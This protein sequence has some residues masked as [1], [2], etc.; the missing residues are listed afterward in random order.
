MDLLEQLINHLDDLDNPAIRDFIAQHEYSDPA[1]IALKPH[2]GIPGS[3]LA[4]QIKARLKAK[5]KLPTYYQEPGVIYPPMA[6]LAQTS[7]ELTAIHKLNFL[8]SATRASQLIDLT[9]G[10]GID[11]HFLAK[12]FDVTHIEPNKNLQAL[13][14]FNH[15]LLG[16][17]LRYQNTDAAD[18]L[19][20]HF[21]E[22]IYY[23]DPSRLDSN[24]NRV[25]KLEEC[26]PDVRLIHE[27]TRQKVPLLLKLSPL[28]DIT[29]L[30]KTL[31]D[32]S[33]VRVVAVQN[34]VKEVLALYKPGQLNTL[35]SAVNIGKESTS[36]FSFTPDEEI[37]SQSDISEPLEYIYEPFLS[38][39]K[40]GAFKLFG[41]RYQ[42]HKLN[43]HCHLYTSRTYDPSIPARVFK[44][45]G[46]VSKSMPPASYFPDL[47][48]NILVR[49]YP[50]STAELRKKFKLNDGGNYYLIGTSGP[51]SNMLIATTRVH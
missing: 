43:P 50:Q 14:K 6:N 31:P 7:S 33:E 27:I 24:Q 9:G 2:L 38:I 41:S 47:T 1:R 19:N 44:V 5:S 36:H 42:L 20:S 21:T 8:E 48:A 12:S 34:E 11:S 15:E 32:C 10:F 28:L 30:L 40:A 39:V 37:N 22:A 16:T 3:I 46:F 25:F 29:T 51:D 35:I 17:S 18:Y 13:A 4:N 45:M 23:A 26:I 49:N